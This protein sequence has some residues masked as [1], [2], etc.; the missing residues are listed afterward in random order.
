MFSIISRNRFFVIAIITVIFVYVI[1]FFT[2]SVRAS[3][4]DAGSR[5]ATLAAL[6]RQI[7]LSCSLS[8][9]SGNHILRCQE[10]REL[11]SSLY[12]DAVSTTQSDLNTLDRMAILATEIGGSDSGLRAAIRDTRSRFAHVFRDH[13]G[14][15]Q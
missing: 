9:T 14:R 3:S 2:P 10:L 13:G 12:R 5:Q 1:L 11:H 7:N 6:M 15:W 4:H 8:N